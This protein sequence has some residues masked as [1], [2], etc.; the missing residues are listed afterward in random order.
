MSQ[1]IVLVGSLS[2]ENRR[3]YSGLVGRLGCAAVT[4]RSI[5]EAQERIL[6]RKVEVGIL[7]DY[8]WEESGDA[9]MMDRALKGLIPDFLTMYVTDKYKTPLLKPMRIIDKCAEESTRLTEIRAGIAMHFPWRGQLKK[10][11]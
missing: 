5:A 3:T 4:P 2:E 7:D 1:L 11:A 8:G 10:G 6:A 9:V